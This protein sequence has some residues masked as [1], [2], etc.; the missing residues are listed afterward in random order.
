[1]GLVHTYR[2]YLQNLSTKCTQAPALTKV[3]STLSIDNIPPPPGLETNHVIQQRQYRC[4]R[5]IRVCLIVTSERVDKSTQQGQEADKEDRL[6]R[7]ASK[8]CLQT[9]C[10]SYRCMKV[11]QNK[12]FY[13]QRTILCCLFGLDQPQQ[14]LFQHLSLMVGNGYSFVLSLLGV[15]LASS[16]TTFDFLVSN[17][18]LTLGCSAP[19]V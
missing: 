17:T 16:C 8:Y 13:S 11:L 4:V 3:Q 6:Q 9:C 5:T 10:K 19:A 14:V 2:Q 18:L 12:T 1:M 15:I 7:E